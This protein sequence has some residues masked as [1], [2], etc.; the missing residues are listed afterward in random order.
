MENSEEEIQFSCYNSKIKSFETHYVSLSF[1]NTYKLKFDSVHSILC[2]ICGQNIE[3]QYIRNGEYN[4][5]LENVTYKNGKKDGL[6]LRFYSNDKL[7]EKSNWNNGVLDG[8]CELWY[9][10]TGKI[11]KRMTYVNG[12][13]HGLFQYWAQD[14]TLYESKNYV[15]GVI[16]NN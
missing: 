16:E 13:L 2:P 14:G 5:A 11:M 1:F 10:T 9:D 12:K 15:N 3:N 4:S 7:Y 8:V 6:Y